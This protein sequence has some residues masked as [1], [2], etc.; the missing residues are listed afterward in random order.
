MELLILLVIEGLLLWFA[1]HLQNT[2]K[3][4]YDQGKMSLEK[5]G[6]TLY[7]LSHLGVLLMAITLIAN[8]VVS[9]VFKLVTVYCI[10]LT[11]LLPFVFVWISVRPLNLAP[12]GYVLKGKQLVSLNIYLERR[13]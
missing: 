8:L 9:L 2:T 6:V 12:D 5:Y 3:K 10:S 7:Y 4:K 11:E 1:I 13:S